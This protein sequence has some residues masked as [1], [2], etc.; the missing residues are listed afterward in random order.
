LRKRRVG[1][2]IGTRARYKRA[3]VTLVS[4]D[5]ITFFEDV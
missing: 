5:S 1:K 4:E 3:I 2:F